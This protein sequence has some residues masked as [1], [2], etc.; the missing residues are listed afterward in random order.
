MSDEALKWWFLAQN[1]MD[2][3]S[4]AKIWIQNY[5]CVI[6]E[7]FAFLATG[8]PSGRMVAAKRIGGK[9]QAITPVQGIILH[10]FLAP[11]A[12]VQVC[13]HVWSKIRRLFRR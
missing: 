13:S 9:K 12:Y 1:G 11:G 3:S 10:I 2:K 8:R 4:S 7:A 5:N 6:F